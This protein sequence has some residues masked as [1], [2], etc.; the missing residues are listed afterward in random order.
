[1]GTETTI[2]RKRLSDTETARLVVD[3]CPPD[4]RACGNAMTTI[5]AWHPRYRMSD[6]EIY[7]TEQEFMEKSWTSWKET[8]PSSAPRL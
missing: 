3:E 7:G 8:G 1:M 5:V 6:T 2:A 4:P